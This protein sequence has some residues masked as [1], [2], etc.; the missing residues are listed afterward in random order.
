VDAGEFISVVG[1]SGCGKSTILRIAAGLED[2]TS[3]IVEFEGLA[4]EGPSR[5]RGLVFQS[6][7]AFPWLTV[8]ENVAFGLTSPQPAYT[9]DRW[10]YD[11][12]L[13][14]FGNLY[15]KALSGGMRQ[16]LAIARAM[17]V[18]PKLLLLDEPFGALDERTRSSMQELLLAVTTRNRCTVLLVTHDIREAVLLSH[19]IIV[20]SARPGRIQDTVESTL[21]TPRSREQSKTP[22]F[23]RLYRHVSDQW[24]PEPPPSIGTRNAEHRR[25][26]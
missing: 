25:G 19:R 21:A 26:T 16:R 18:E 1:P 15:P 14:E 3:G 5:E 10:L 23:E 6:Y 20:I 11:M 7:N 13:S 12:G 9:I 4:V 22:E 8:R 2:P 24:L 17:I